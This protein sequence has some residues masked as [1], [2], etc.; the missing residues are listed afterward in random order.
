MRLVDLS[1]K[2]QPMWR[3]PVESKLIKDIHRGDP[4]QVTSVSTSMHAFTHVDT[5]LHIEPGRE[6]VDEVDLS[7]LCG[8][9]AIINL[10]PVAANQQLGYD[11]LKQRARHVKEADVVIL[12]TCW[13]S[14]RDYTT[15]SY[16]HD[17]PYLSTEAECGLPSSRSKQLASIFRRIMSFGK[18]Q[19]VIRPLQKCPPMT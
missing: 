5:P 16:W 4:Y 1:M 8:P 7:R 10:T 3:W 13:D 11:Y 14:M 2:I 9:A 19:T 17:A 6:S 12:K 18:F 15:E